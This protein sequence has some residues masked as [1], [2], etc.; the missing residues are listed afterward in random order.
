MS[1]I[2]ALRA[3]ALAAAIAA[4]C[5][6]AG[7][8]AT[9]SLMRLIASGDGRYS[10][11]VPAAWT[12]PHDAAELS[13]V[14]EAL[15]AVDPSLHGLF[16]DALGRGLPFAVDMS[17]LPGALAW[18]QISIDSGPPALTDA[19]L[20]A[21]L[22]ALRSDPN[23]KDAEADFVDLPA[24]RAA[25]FRWTRQLGG[26][27]VHISD[28]GF[29][30]RSREGDIVS[31]LHVVE[32]QPQP[33]LVE[34]I[35]A[36]LQIVPLLTGTVTIESHGGI[37]MPAT[38]VS[39][40]CEPRGPG[41]SGLAMSG[42][43]PGPAGAIHLDFEVDADARAVFFQE[44][45]EGVFY[46]AGKGWEVKD[47]FHTVPGSTPAKGSATF[48]GLFDAMTGGNPLSGSITWTCDAS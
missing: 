42:E 21:R 31:V 47:T 48:A 33:G 8:P 10:M 34:G 27:L 12:T 11:G 20:Q 24:G 25:R 26:Y 35:A 4:A 19:D 7:T 44:A 32:S 15:G 41:T 29:P 45:A 5:G 17:V 18:A 40:V 9:A 46:F 28:Y 3:I 36:S 39:V 14:Q 38:A 30:G 22:G 6:T 43:V 13:R 23:I 1:R 37:E 2:R 16:S